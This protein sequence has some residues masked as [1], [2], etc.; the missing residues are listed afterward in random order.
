MLTNR[1]P[2]RLTVAG[3][4][5]EPLNTSLGITY[6]ELNW[7]YATNSGALAVGCVIFIPLAL[8]FGRRPVYIAT[9]AILTLTSVWQAKQ[10]NR[11]DMFGAQVLSGLAGATNETLIQ[12]TVSLLCSRDRARTGARNVRLTM[13]P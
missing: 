2:S 6:N 5:W 12:L 7:A 8:K 13:W 1:V 3:P 11:G 4:L 10:T 9:S